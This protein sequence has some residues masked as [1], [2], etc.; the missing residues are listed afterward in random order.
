MEITAILPPSDNKIDFDLLDCA[1]SGPDV[2]IVDDFELHTQAPVSVIDLVGSE[3]QV[4]FYVDCVR[5][6]LVLH[7]KSVDK[8]MKVKILC[9][10]DTGKD[11]LFEMSNKSSFVTIDQ[12]TCKMPMEVSNGWQYVCIELDELLANAFGTS[13]VSCKQVTLCGSCRVSKM[14]FQSRKYADV[15]LPD[16]LRVVVREN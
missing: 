14:F 10:D 1:A 16:F 15:E 3:S 7:F 8:F 12:T 4:V 2:N 11:K 5:P 13:L 6:Y 9:S